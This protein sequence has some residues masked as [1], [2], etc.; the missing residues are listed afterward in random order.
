MNTIRVMVWIGDVMMSR[1]GVFRLLVVSYG[2]LYTRES[3]VGIVWLC[4]GFREGGWGGGN[5]E[6]SSRY[7]RKRQ[8]RDRCNRWAAFVCEQA[9]KH[10][11]V[12]TS[13]RA[14]VSLLKT[15]P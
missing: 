8:I 6:I 7:A 10:L 12:K 1:D 15:V 4:C 11:C 13:F 9:R 14:S 3:V 2:I 5:C